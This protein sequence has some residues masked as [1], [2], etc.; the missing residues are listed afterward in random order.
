M[1]SEREKIIELLFNDM[2][3][4]TR[5]RMDGGYNWEGRRLI[6]TRVNDYLRDVYG[7]YSGEERKIIINTV[8]DRI[9][10]TFSGE[11]TIYNDEIDD[12]LMRM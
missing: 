6:K 8:C 11:D 7:V 9:I 3:R 1:K 5:K 10:D 12:L 4:R 2:I